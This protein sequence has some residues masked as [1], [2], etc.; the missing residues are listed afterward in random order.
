[1]SGININRMV[2]GMVDTNCYLVYQDIIMEEGA[3]RP[4]VIIDPGDN[5]PFILNRCKELQVK[6]AAIL[7]THGHGD[8][9]MAAED[10]RRAF[11]IP[12]IASVHE[13]DMLQDPDKNLTHTFGDS[14]Q[15]TADYLV[16]D[17]EELKLL[18]RTWK[19]IETPGHTPGCICFY[20]QEDNILF[21]GD[22]LFYRSVGR[23]D[24]PGGNMR[25]LLNS[26]FDKLFVL[27]DETLVYPGHGEYTSIA[28]EKKYNMISG[29]RR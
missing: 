15:V 24:L 18:D 23:T 8:H 26:V 16:K 12:V 6:P 1:M 5:A 29:Y 22:T 7:L 19:V 9:I 10:I 17:G 3:L 11:H 14:I 27:P 2:V 28:F 25:S 13:E 20:L 4:A 21:A